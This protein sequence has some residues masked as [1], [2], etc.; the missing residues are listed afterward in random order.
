[1][2]DLPAHRTRSLT[3][4]QGRE[5]GRHH[6]FTTAMD[7]PIYFCDPASPWQRGSNENTNRLPRRYSPTCIGVSG[8]VIGL[9]AHA[10]HSAAKPRP[11]ACVNSSEPA[12]AVLAGPKVMACLRQNGNDS[13]APVESGA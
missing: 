4:D 2:R 11:S 7:I 3:G 12:P 8:V 13:R 10:K 5:R 1:M 9:A 6:E